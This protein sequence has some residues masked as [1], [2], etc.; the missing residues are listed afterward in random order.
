MTRYLFD[1]DALSFITGN[2]LARYSEY[3]DFLGYIPREQ[4]FTCAPVVGELYAGAPNHRD[5]ASMVTRIEQVLQRLTVLPLDR[6]AAEKYGYLRARLGKRGEILQDMDLMIAACALPHGMT[7]VT[8]NEKH[9]SR[10]RELPLWVVRE[11]RV[12]EKMALADSAAKQGFKA[13][14]KRLPR[15]KQA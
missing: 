15:K 4:Q 14:K 1:A 6:A 9:F 11:R 2:R 7:L 5:P 12:R 3:A 13:A 10:I 8:G